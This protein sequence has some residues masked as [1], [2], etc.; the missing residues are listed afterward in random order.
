M[1]SVD[2][3]VRVIIGGELA[4][5]CGA[6]EWNLHLSRPCP[7]EA[8]HAIN[9]NTGGRLRKYLNTVG[10]ARY[11][12]IALGREDNPL[13]REE[14]AQPTGKND[15]YLI[16]VPE[17]QEKGWQKIVV[18]VILAI[19]TYGAATPAIAG[20]LGTSVAVMQ[21]VGYGLAASLILG[22]V[23]QMLTPT[24]SFD[25]TTTSDDGRGSNIFG[26]NASTV[27]QGIPLG[28]VY[29]RALVAPL[30]ISV[31]FTA[32]DQAIVNSFD[33]VVGEGGVIEYVP[34]AKDPT[35]GLPQE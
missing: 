24:P 17:G 29:G 22:G 7:A 28:L 3:P 13:G 23:T 34:K 19:V 16:P 18:G 4:D 14:L 32:I 2:T 11:Y 9:V 33:I 30:P 25:S 10:A 12:R 1:A 5:V 31:S 6:A 21:T 35:A 8:I 26:G 27:F 15:I 20:Y